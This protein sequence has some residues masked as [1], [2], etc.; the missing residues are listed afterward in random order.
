MYFFFAIVVAG[1]YCLNARA[2]AL[3]TQDLALIIAVAVFSMLGLIDQ[4]R[5]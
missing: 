5:R 2:G 4:I 1:L 3:R